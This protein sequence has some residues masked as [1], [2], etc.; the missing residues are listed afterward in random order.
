MHIFFFRVLK[1]ILK[2]DGCSGKRKKTFANDDID[3]IVLGQE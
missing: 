2:V 3:M 1:R